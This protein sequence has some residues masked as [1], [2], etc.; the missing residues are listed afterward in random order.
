MTTPRTPQNTNQPK[1]SRLAALVGAGTLAVGAM[2]LT[3][4]A[5]NADVK[6]NCAALGGTYQGSW[7]DADEGTHAHVEVCCYRS[8]NSAVKGQTCDYYENGVFISTFR[9]DQTTPPPPKRLPTRSAP[10]PVNQQPDNNPGPNNPPAG[11]PGA[12]HP[13][14]PPS[15]NPGN[16]NQPPGGL[17]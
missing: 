16:N 13:P 9:G 10:P 2:I 8:L 7:K 11:V 14:Q 5:A 4:P 12:F 1:R 17:Q 15:N 6:S 3:A